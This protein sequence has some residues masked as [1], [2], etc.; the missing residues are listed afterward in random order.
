MI[1]VDTNILVHAHRADSV[2]HAAATAFLAQVART[3]VFADTA[4]DPGSARA[5][6]QAALLPVAQGIAQ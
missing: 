4:R 5:H 1:A 2:W 3:L 6:V